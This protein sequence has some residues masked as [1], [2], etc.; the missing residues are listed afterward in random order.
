M[1]SANK[2]A[3]VVLIVFAAILF[4]VIVYWAAK[5]AVWQIQDN[6]DT[7]RRIRMYRAEE[8]QRRIAALERELFGGNDG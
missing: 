3:A 5:E 4:T 1:D 8:R 7:K 6:R 2:V